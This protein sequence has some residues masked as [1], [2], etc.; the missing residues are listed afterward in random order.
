MKVGVNG[1]VRDISDLKV[2]VSGAVRAVSEGYAGVGGAVKKIWPVIRTLNDC[3]WDEISE[4]SSSGEAASMFKVGDRKEIVLNGTVGALTFNDYHTY[5]FIIG[6]DHNASR[7][8]SNRIH[9]QLAKTAL[10]GG[11]DI[12]FV[13]SNYNST[14]SSAGFR[15]NTSNTN[16]GGWEDSYMRSSICGTSKSSTSG[17]FM[18]AIPSALRN[19]LKSVSKYTDNTGGGGGS[20]SSHVTRTTDYIFLL[21]EY[22][23]FGTITNGNTYEANYQ[24]QYAYYSAG[25]SKIKYRHNSTGSSARWW[26]RSPGAINSYF[27]RYVYTDGNVVNNGARYSLGFAP[28]FCV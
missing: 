2:G 25:N 20:V 19:V 1:A 9:F 22:E 18:G 6:F 28:G 27:F 13:D 17:R 11:A 23:V 8:G 5:A 3:T 24:Q 15:M 7:E 12:C 16:R 14:G 10:S 21:S 4:I 26:L